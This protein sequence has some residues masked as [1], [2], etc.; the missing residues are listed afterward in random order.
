MKPKYMLDTNI[1]IYL[2]KNQPEHVAQRFAECYVGDVV[3]SAITF[4]ELQFGIE[5][6]GGQQTRHR[7]LLKE[8]VD[9]VPVAPYDQDAAISYGPLR[10]MAASRQR[11]ALDQLIASHAIALHT[12]L[13]TNNPKD[14]VQFHNLQIENWVNP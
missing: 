9:Q 10:F 8:L 11:D 2:M 7:K 5:C 14:F 3:M 1:C 12:T 6:S 4:A 13:V